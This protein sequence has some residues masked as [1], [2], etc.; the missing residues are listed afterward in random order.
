[1]KSN[2]VKFATIVTDAIIDIDKS[3]GSLLSVL[4][5]EEI[6]PVDFGR[7]ARD[8]DVDGPL[9]G[10]NVHFL[11]HVSKRPTSVPVNKLI[12]GHGAS[13]QIVEWQNGDIWDQ[14][15]D[16]TFR[17]VDTCDYTSRERLPSDAKATVFLIDR[18]RYE[19]IRKL[20]GCDTR[21]VKKRGRMWEVTPVDG[22]AKK[23]KNVRMNG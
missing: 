16:G 18:E 12:C 10:R 9:S 13:I 22:V 15:H 6:Q 5:Y 1:M 4:Y 3:P 19:R 21:I 11:A 8:T 2:R 14:L 17:R 23:A 20:G 7:A